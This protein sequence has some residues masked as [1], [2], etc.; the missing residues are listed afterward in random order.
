MITNS[1]IDRIFLKDYHYYTGQIN[2]LWVE[3]NCLF[4]K[5]K[6]FFVG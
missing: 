6:K 1:I 3:D 4:L 2:L 5:R